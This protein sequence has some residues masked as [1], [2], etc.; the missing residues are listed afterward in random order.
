MPSPLE[1][2]KQVLASNEAVQFGVF[3]TI[4]AYPCFPPCVFLNEF[5][6]VG[7]DPC[8]Q[9]GRMGSWQ[10]FA[11][12]AEE[13]RELLAWWVAAHHGAVEDNLGA[14]SWGD[15]VQVVLNLWETGGVPP[16]HAPT[17]ESSA[18]AD[19]GE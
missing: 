1:L 10:P 16:S 15:W 18:P 14:T 5:L 4:G 17:A 13:Y 11:V 2:A 6:G 8:D 19:D 7:Y 12:S 9:D 3:G